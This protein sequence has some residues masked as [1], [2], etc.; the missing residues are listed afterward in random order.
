MRAIR[1]VRH[2]A[3]AAPDA[4]AEV[5]F[6]EGVL[7]LRTVARRPAPE[8]G[9]GVEIVLFGAGEGPADAFLQIICVG[10]GRPPGRLGGNGPYS[11]NLSVPRDSLPAWERRLRDAHV[12]A[13]RVVRLG[14]ERIEL[15][16]P[17]GLTYSLVAADGGG[18]GEGI[19]GLH[20]ATLS[21]VDVRDCHAFLTEI[22]G[23]THERQDVA[24][25]VYR[26]EPDAP[27]IELVHEPYRSPGTWT[28][29]SGT[30]HHV[31]IEVDGVEP[32]RLLRTRLREAGLADVSEVTEVGGVASTWV[33]IPGGT[34]VELTCP[35]DAHG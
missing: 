23:A 24:D 25:G 20:G 7:G 26:F 15:R 12:T 10:S 22:L 2:V 18:P 13:E 1:G 35:A 11:V 31:A 32:L 14:G 17:L 4:D 30:P 6:H 3:F 29:A 34:L 33:R 16:H 8:L 9:A 28:L 19:R 21:L 27:G 5:A